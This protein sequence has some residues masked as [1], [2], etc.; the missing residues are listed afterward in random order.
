MS[1][2]R[3]SP[4]STQMPAIATIHEQSMIRA[5]RFGVSS[6]ARRCV[7]SLGM[8]GLVAAHAAAQRSP[9]A[10]AVTPRRATHIADSLLALMTLDEKLGQL[11]QA[12]AGFVQ[13]GPAVDAGG[14][15]LLRE[16]K[17][18]SLLNLYGADVTRRT[19][20]IAVEESRLHIPLLLG[21]D[22]IHGMR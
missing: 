10:T 11:T 3:R 17:L 7:T 20:R 13:T 6:V 15:R 21:Y 4:I 9:A 8:T 14:E 1:G 18:G 2:V 16:G 19:Q 12:P 5:R 22:V